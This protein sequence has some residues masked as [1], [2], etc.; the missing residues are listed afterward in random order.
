MSYKHQESV[1]WYWRNSDLKDTPDGHILPDQ[2]TALRLRGDASSIKHGKAIRLRFAKGQRVNWP[3]AVHPFR[4]LSCQPE[5]WLA[6][7]DLEGDE[8]AHAVLSDIAG[9]LKNAAGIPAEGNTQQEKEEKVRLACPQF[10]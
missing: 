5:N 8:Y 7:R 4:G 9:W 3:K 2:A 10:Q 6:M 1:P